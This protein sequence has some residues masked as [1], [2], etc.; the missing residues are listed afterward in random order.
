MAEIA[1]EMVWLRSFLKD[2]SISSPPPMPMY[3]DN[4]AVIFI[5]DNSTFHEHTK[6]IDIDCHYIRDKVM[7]GVIST[8]HVASSHQLADIFTKSLV[9]ISYDVTCTKLG[10][11]DSN[12]PS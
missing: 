5:E 9:G 8:P 3:C 12:A 6:H 2:L 1:R 4:Q 11:F 7:L 10:M